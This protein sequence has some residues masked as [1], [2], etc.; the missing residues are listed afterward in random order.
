MYTKAIG[1]AVLPNGTL[2]PAP[3]YD[4]GWG[5]PMGN[6]LHFESIDE[7]IYIYIYISNL[8]VITDLI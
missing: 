4:L 1:V 2:I 5:N 3:L 6:L 8:F 7:Y